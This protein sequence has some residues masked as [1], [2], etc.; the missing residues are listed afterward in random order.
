MA[1]KHLLTPSKLTAGPSTND[2]LEDYP[3]SKSNPFAEDMYL[4][5]QRRYPPKK[6]VYLN[7]NRKL[8]LPTINFQ[9]RR[10]P[11]SMPPVQPTVPSL[12]RCAF[13]A[14]EKRVVRNAG[15]G[16]GVSKKVWRSMTWWWH[17][18][19]NFA[20]SSFSAGIKFRNFPEV[21]CHV[22]CGRGQMGNHTHMM[23]FVCCVWKLWRITCQLHLRLG[24]SVQP[25]CLFISCWSEHVR[26]DLRTQQPSRVGWL[27]P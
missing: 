27:I 5:W 23:V 8:H 17:F 16:L 7:F 4:P 26:I 20:C 14:V 18:L 13:G 2:N 19:E 11:N 12:E 1:K 6:R 24:I 21:K 22:L 9:T 25:S 10:W 15:R 3:F